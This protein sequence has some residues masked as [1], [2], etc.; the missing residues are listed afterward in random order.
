MMLIS[1]S[2][3]AQVRHVYAA[4]LARQEALAFRARETGPASWDVVIVFGLS[5]PIAFIDP[6]AG[7]LT[8]LALL[9]AGRVLAPR[10][11]PT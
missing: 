3:L 6:A 7:M 10:P 4:D 1:A 9:V 5:I 2:Y 8:W 11:G